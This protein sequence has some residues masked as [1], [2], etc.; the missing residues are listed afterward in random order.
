MSS[1]PMSTGQAGRRMQHGKSAQTSGKKAAKNK[2]G[3]WHRKS[4]GKTTQTASR[5]AR[6]TD[7]KCPAEERKR[8]RE[9]ESGGG[10][11][12]LQKWTPCHAKCCCILPC[13]FL[14]FF[15]G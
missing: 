7:D 10:G 14:L 15:L 11:G 6:C 1:S 8:E 3:K 9:R 13:F 2:V 5:W 4:A 12:S